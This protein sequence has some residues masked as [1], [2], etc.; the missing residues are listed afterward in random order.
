MKSVVACNLI[1]ALTLALGSFSLAQDVYRTKNGTLMITL[2]DQGEMLKFHTNTL[3][4]NLNLKTAEFEF[5]VPVNSLH[6]S[7]DSLNYYLKR[8]EIDIMKFKGVLNLDEIKTEPHEPYNFKFIADLE[9][10][11]LNKGIEGY[12]RLEHIPGREQPACQL[13]LSFEM[14]DFEIISGIRDDFRFQL[15]QSILYQQGI[16]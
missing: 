4:I 15:I 8:N 6:S 3:Q 9:Y 14:G 7:V 11:G 5:W 16:N 2:M 10:Q 12:G 1:V 13:S